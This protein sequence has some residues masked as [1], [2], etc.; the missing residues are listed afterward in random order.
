M[1]KAWKSVIV[2]A[3]IAIV[4]GSGAPAYAAPAYAPTRAPAP[5]QRGESALS[6][7]PERPSYRL[8]DK[9]VATGR[10]TR[11]DGT[12]VAGVKVAAMLDSDIEH[13]VG[14]VTGADGAWRAE[15]QFQPGRDPLG[16]HSMMV[17]FPGNETLRPAQASAQFLLT[18][19]VAPVILRAEPHPDPVYPGGQVSLRGTMHSATDNAPLADKNVYLSDPKGDPIDFG[20]TNDKGEW[21]ITLTVPAQAGTQAAAF[22]RYPLSLHY[23]GDLILGSAEQALELTLGAKDAPPTPQP[24]PERTARGLSESP[25]P[26]PSPAYPTS[27]GGASLIPGLSPG[28][29]MLGGGIAA[30]VFGAALISHGIRR[31]SG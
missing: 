23:D 8:G 11:A 1:L 3:A 29:L 21:Q 28:Q 18:G 9:P 14:A 12:P 2:A 19:N 24:S 27:R 25:S 13:Q 15:L 17:G 30:V 26:T 31:R 16:D 10:L 7:Q 5:T 22:P 6:V 4:P 20:W